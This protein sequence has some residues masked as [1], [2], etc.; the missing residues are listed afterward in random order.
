MVKVR[1][2]VPFSGMLAAP[3]ALMITGGEVAVIEALDVLPVPPSVEVTVTLLFFTP[4][5]VLVISTETVH[6]ALTA[7]VPPAKLTDVAFATAVVVPPQVLFAFGGLA[8]IKPA[9]RLSVNATP[10]RATFEFGFW[11]VKV[12]VVKPPIGCKGGLNELVIVGGAATV[13]FAVAVPPAPLLVPPLVEVMFPVVLVYWPDAAPVTVTENGQ[14]PAATVMLAPLSEIVV[15]LVVVRV[16]PQTELELVAT[17]KP[18]GRVSVKPTPVSVAVLPIGW[19]M[20]KFSDVVWFRGMLLGT[21]ILLTLGGAT[22]VKTAVAVAPVPPSVDV[23]APVVLFLVPLP[24]PFTSTEKVHDDPAAGEAVSVPPD[25]LIV[26]LFC[27]AVIVPAPQEPVT[28]GGLA[29]ATFVGRSS[30]NATPLRGLAVF[31]FVMAELSM[32]VPPNGTLVGLKALLIVGGATTV[33]LAFD[34]LPVPPSVE[35]T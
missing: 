3:N 16:P 19:L 10:V 5:V 25:K 4:S 21:K 30:G 34:V 17:V 8:R 15:G 31:G 7:S 27:T 14:D 32:L 22:T 28:F 11:I 20:L 23:T 2:V 6:E 12:K 13:R 35:A 26:V 9:G 1:L 18:A 33:R 29:T 24:S